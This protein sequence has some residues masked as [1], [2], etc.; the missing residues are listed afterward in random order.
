[1]RLK[2][3]QCEKLLGELGIWV[4]DACDKSGSCSAQFGGLGRVSLGN[5][6]RKPAR[7]EWVHL[8]QP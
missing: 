6:V 2:Q 1:M 4:T 3:E 5:G 7:T 8:S